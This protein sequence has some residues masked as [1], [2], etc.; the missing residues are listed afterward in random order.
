MAK[1]KS[2]SALERTANILKQKAI[3]T[4]ETVIEKLEEK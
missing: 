3:K 1:A 4:A 2:D